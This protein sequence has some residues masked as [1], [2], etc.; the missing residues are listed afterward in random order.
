MH[1]V[2]AQCKLNTHTKPHF[3]LHMKQLLNCF[4]LRLQHTPWNGHPTWPGEQVNTKVNPA[5]FSSSQ[6]PWSSW[7]TSLPPTSRGKSSGSCELLRIIWG[8][9]RKRRHA[10]RCTLHAARRML[11]VLHKPQAAWISRSIRK[12]P[13]NHD[14]TD[15]RFVVEIAG[16]FGAK[17]KTTIKL[18]RKERDYEGFTHGYKLHS[19]KGHAT[20]ATATATCTSRHNTKQIRLCF[21]IWLLDFIYVSVPLS[22]AL[23]FCRLCKIVAC[24][25]WPLLLGLNV[26]A[27][28]SPNSR[29]CIIDR[30][31]S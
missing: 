15:V 10:T 17:K 9:F 11:H 1:I 28:R 6:H 26:L 5:N 29:N 8:K 20:I 23:H 3:L 2:C 7:S 19:A 25:Y 18:R 4:H 30:S 13:L 24:N 12:E 22:V 21:S 16:N 27:R 14:W 31:W